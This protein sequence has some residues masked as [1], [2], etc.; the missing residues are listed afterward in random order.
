MHRPTRKL[1]F[2]CPLC[3]EL[4]HLQHFTANNGQLC[5]ECPACLERSVYSADPSHDSA[6]RLTP[7][8]PS[9][10]SFEQSASLL[11]SATISSKTPDASVVPSAVSCFLGGSLG[12]SLVRF[13]GGSLSDSF[14]RFLGSTESLGP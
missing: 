3:K 2:Q 6:D 8:A 9:A 11:E 12:G 13:L 10:G 1:L 5:I 7:S 4:V 14:G